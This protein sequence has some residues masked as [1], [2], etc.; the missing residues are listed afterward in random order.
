MRTGTAH[1]RRAARPRPASHPPGAWP[2]RE[3]RG[4]VPERGAGGHARRSA[5]G[6]VVRRA[7]AGETRTLGTVPAERAAAVGTGGLTPLVAPYAQRRVVVFGVGQ[8]IATSQAPPQTGAQRGW[9]PTRHDP[10]DPRS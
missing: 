9:P 5:Q 1:V 4:L 8:A 6:G 3:A 2:S 7:V 10:F